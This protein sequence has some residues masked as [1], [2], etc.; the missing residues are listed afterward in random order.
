MTPQHVPQPPRRITLQRW[1]DMGIRVGGYADLCVAKHLLHHL[2]FNAFP[3][4]ICRGSVAKVVEAHMRETFAA[5]H[6]RECS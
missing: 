2:Q 1:H 5:Q 6:A 3:E 4:H